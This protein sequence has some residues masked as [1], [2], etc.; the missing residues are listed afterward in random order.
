MAKFDHLT[1]AVA[2][3]IRS[4]DWYVQHIGLKIEF[5]LPERCTAALQDESGFTI[6]VQQSDRMTGP[7]GIALYFSVTDVDVTH[8]NLSAAGVVFAHPPQKT[9]WGYGAE[10]RDPDAY[11]V[12]LWDERSMNG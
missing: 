6:F 2:N 11:V 5:E 4:R 12:R 3:W 8:R 9:F 10:L 7:I 1:L